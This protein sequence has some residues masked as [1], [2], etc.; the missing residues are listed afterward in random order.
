MVDYIDVEKTDNP[1]DHIS[2]A[3]CV[4]PITGHEQ[5]YR[6]TAGSYADQDMVTFVISESELESLIGQIKRLKEE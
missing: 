6:I 4:P 5:K 1:W 3:K 2:I